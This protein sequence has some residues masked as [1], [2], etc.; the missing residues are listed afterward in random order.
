MATEENKPAQNANL[1]DLEV[2]KLSRFFELLIKL[3]DRRKKQLKQPK[4]TDTS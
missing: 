4:P 2:Q 1:T 3:E